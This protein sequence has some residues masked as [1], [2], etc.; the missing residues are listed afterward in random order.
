MSECISFDVVGNVVKRRDGFNPVRGERNYTRL[1]FYFKPGYGWDNCEFLTCSFFVSA[2]QM[3]KSVPVSFDSE[4]GYADFTIPGEYQTFSGRLFVAVQGTYEEN[5]ETVTVSS[6]IACVDVSKGLLVEEGAAQG[7]Y[8][9][10][11][12]LLNTFK[13]NVNDALDELENNKEDKINKALVIDSQSPTDGDEQYP[14]VNAVRSYTD[15]RNNDLKDYVDE[16]LDAI[17]EAKAD[18]TEVETVT[19]RVRSLI[20]IIAGK[21]DKSDTYTIQGTNT[22]IANAVAGLVSES[23]LPL[24]STLRASTDL[25]S[26]QINSICT[27]MPDTANR[28]NGVIGI[29]LTLGTTVSGGVKAQ[30]ILSTASKIFLRYK[31]GNGA[32]YTD[33][34]EISSVE[35]T[36]TAIAN[37]VAGLVSE[38]SLPLMSTLRASTDLDSEQVNSICT[39]LS[40]TANR[41]TGVMGIC[42]TLGTT[43]GGGVIAQLILSTTSKIYLRY[44]AGNGAVYGAWTECASVQELE[45]LREELV[46]EGTNLLYLPDGTFNQA[47]A[48]SI[49]AVVKDQVITLSG[50]AGSAAAFVNIPVSVNMGAGTYT[51]KRFLDDA[52]FAVLLTKDTS[53]DVTSRIATVSK[54][55][56]TQPNYNTVTLSTSATAKYIRIYVLAGTSVDAEF[57]LQLKKSSTVPNA[58]ESPV[59]LKEFLMPG[60][61]LMSTLKISTDLDSE[62]VNSIC[63]VRDYT[64]NRPTGVVGI[65]L[66][67]GTTRAGGI[68][69]QLVLSA[70]PK[71]YLRYKAG[72]GAVYTEWSEISSVEGTNTA[73]A[74]A[75]AGLVSESSLPLMSTLGKSTDLNNEQINSICTVMSDTANR[76]TGVM[77]ICLTLGTTR[78]GG[79]I[80]QLILSTTSKIY[81]RYK[82][83]NGAVYGAWKECASAQELEQLR[84]KLEQ[85]REELVNEGTNLLYL[86]DGTFEQSSTGNIKAVIK[87]QVITLSGTANGS[88]GA[89][90]NIPISVNM[91]A[92]TYTLKRFL[93]DAKFAVMLT[94]DTS[95]TGIS[96]VSAGDATKPNYNTVT[97]SATV[98]AKYI[99][100][101]VPPTL[102]AG[103]SVAAKFQLQLKKSSTVPNA[104]ESPVLLKKFLMPGLPLMST[105]GK[106]TDL[107]NEQINSICTVMSDTANRP[108]G[109]IGICLTLGTTVSGGVKAQLI[110]STASK[111]FLRYKAGN[112][113]IYTDWSEIGAGQGSQPEV[114]V[115]PA[116]DAFGIFDTVGFI[117]DSLGSGWADAN[118][119]LTK[120]D[121]T[122]NKNDYDVSWLQFM[123]RRT[124]RTGYNFSYGGATTTSWLTNQKGAALLQTAGYK[125]QAY[126]IGLGVNDSR[127]DSTI[128][129]PASPVSPEAFSANYAN[130]INT[131]RSVSEKAPIFCIKIPKDDIGAYANVSAY[132]TAISDIVSN[133]AGN[134][135][136][137]I[138]PEVAK[139][140]SLFSQYKD[141]YHYSALGYARIAEYMLELLNACVEENKGDFVQL[142]LL[143]SDPKEYYTKA[144]VDALI[145]SLRN[146]LSNS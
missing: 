18:K 56:A 92:E 48:G 36:N 42:L 118:G 65:C 145:E 103:T 79:V 39:V 53:T 27:V 26:E 3:T 98:T 88:T 115:P 32:N 86:P 69:A 130:I 122:L 9:R 101:Y 17:D 46:N 73:I 75:V 30:L 63:T 119:E 95:S 91:E 10:L 112:G 38:S 85:F 29:C 11:M 68:I 82:A 14:T 25:N 127:I 89:F 96:T 78:G 59:L 109:V 28:P 111:I 102:A 23:S 16:E 5:G 107:N 142:N 8:E 81:L 54:G 51:L 21:A 15:L 138:E 124:G 105:L 41:P 141:I 61:P 110:L 113:A 40:T 12:V 7:L 129:P 34:T 13:V 76:P 87:D 57:Q 108:T 126:I 90:V 125:C 45:Q 72:N 100:I 99:R 83:G 49:T 2:D 123:C 60:L 84:E 93:D 135:V 20:T 139:I 133:N 134:S 58:W 136:Y 106:S 97:L 66:T 116:I 47:G 117:G 94:K 132:N 24:M 44:K 62:Q 80:A 67:L 146:E 114:K 128:D 131:I 31:A 74:N 121:P 104:W 52:N 71:I 77:G 33:W 55:N 1:R 22:A 144:E 70:T 50:T 6:N 37:A 64:A 137:L 143:E 43:R 19:D 4:T 120:D 140:N 35:G